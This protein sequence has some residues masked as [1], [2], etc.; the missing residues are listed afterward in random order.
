MRKTLFALLTAGTMGCGSSPP[1]LHNPVELK[2][3]E[4]LYQNIEYEAS[5]ETNCN[6]WIYVGIEKG[7]L[8]SVLQVEHCLK[9]G[10]T[11][12]NYNW[13]RYEDTN[14]DGKVDTCYLNK[15]N[16][17]VGGR[18]ELPA[19]ATCEAYPSPSHFGD[20]YNIYLLLIDAMQWAGNPSK[21][22]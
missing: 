16:S 7:Q 14:A 17:Y 2:S 21:L 15:G 22:F 11:K 4:R 18:D 8:Q 19:V 9:A 3:N 10:T 20:N 1:V 6:K 13:K 5:H 12:G